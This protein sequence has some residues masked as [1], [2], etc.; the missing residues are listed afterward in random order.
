MQIGHFEARGHGGAIGQCAASEREQSARGVGPLPEQPADEHEQKRRLQ[1]AE[2]EHVDLPNDVRRHDGEHEHEQ[3]HRQR[4][5]LA[6]KGD[7]ALGGRASAVIAPVQVNVLD[8][9]RGRRDEQRRHRGDGRGHR[10]Y[11]GDAR[12]HRRQRGRDD[13]RNDV[14]HTAPVGAEILHENAGGE[15]AERRDAYHHGTD[16][17]RA[18]DHGAVQR[19]HVLVAHSAHHRLRQHEGEHTHEQPLGEVQRRRHGAPGEGLKHLRRGLLDGGH[20][21]LVAAPGG[22]NAPGEHHDSHEHHDAAEGIGHGHAAEAADGGEQDDRHPEQRQTHQVGVPGHRLEEL[23]ASDELGHHGGG[24]EQHDDERRHVRERIGTVAGADDVHYRDRVQLAGDERHL[25]PKDTVE[26]N[27][28]R[29][30]HHG[31]VHPAEA[32]LPCLAGPA[33][34]GAHRAVGG[35]GGHG[36]H[37]AAEGTVAD[38]VAVDEAAP[39]RIGAATHDDARHQGHEQEQ[40][41]RDEGGETSHGGPPPLQRPLRRQRAHRRRPRHH[42]RD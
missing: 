29:H 41:E 21:G 2:G 18:P 26:Q 32:D 6:G 17:N 35:D 15:H 27:K 30:L 1:A 11:D 7:G 19:L 23:R 42:R 36:Q 31:H 39:G 34:K 10:T 20:D 5:R 13:R 12:Q 28:R 9:G 24:E 37:E 22:Q 14:V 38:E 3:A 16:D 33:H 4:H 25:L 8:D 40:D